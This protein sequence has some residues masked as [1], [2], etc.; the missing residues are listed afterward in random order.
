VSVPDDLVA[1]L[2][3]ILDRLAPAGVRATC[4][5][6]GHDDAARLLDAEAAVLT[7]T[8]PAARRASGA[9]RTAARQLLAH[10]GGSGAPILRTP[11]GAPVWPA[12]F[13]GSLAH[14]D[15]VAV[16]AVGRSAAAAGLGIDVEPAEPLP[17]DVA[18]LVVHPR[19]VVA[20]PADPLSS[21]LVFVAKEAVYKAVH[22]LCGLVLDWPDIT[23]DLAAGRAVT[24]TGHVAELF[25]TRAPRLV[26]LAR[27]APD[28]D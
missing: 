2:Q 26:A 21:R 17:A 4:R 8:V 15:T 19:D 6:I 23:V 16:A 9:A 7:T 3:A 10:L 18:D 28:G 14:D 24:V 27:V 25:V 13:V 12:G 1:E 5:R 11:A 22:P 20:D